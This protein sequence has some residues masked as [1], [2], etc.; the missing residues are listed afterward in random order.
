MHTTLFINNLTINHSLKN[1]NR[2]HTHNN[3][4]NRPPGA[5]FYF[6]IVKT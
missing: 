1:L 3:K 6:L 2:F 4:K 5:I